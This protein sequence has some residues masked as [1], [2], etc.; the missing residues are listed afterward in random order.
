VRKALRAAATGFLDFL[1]PPR[2]VGCGRFG[3]WLCEECLAQMPALPAPRRLSAAATP[4][5][6]WSVGPHV[7][8]LRTAV[9]ALKYEEVRVLAVPLAALMARTW[10]AAAP[11][12]DAIVAVPLH[13]HRLRARGYNQSLLLAQALGAEVG[14]PAL[15]DGVERVRETAIQ[16][17]SSAVQRRANV[18]GAFAAGAALRGLAVV[19]VD[20]VCTSGATL[21]A[22]AA[23]VTAAQGQVV[24]ALTV[25]Q[26]LLAEPAP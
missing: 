17:G 8:I 11:P 12:A 26:A 4:L 22:C 20:D 10:Q 18:A 5:D 13:R 1:Y 24:A 23:A 16:V 19:L 7:G 21:E 9:H 6:V 2:C 15:S 14:K 25:T 3:P